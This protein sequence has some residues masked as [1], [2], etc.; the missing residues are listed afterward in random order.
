M[1]AELGGGRWTWLCPR[2]GP[3]SARSRPGSGRPTWEGG[4]V[5][6]EGAGLALGPVPL[7]QLALQGV[8]L[9][10]AA[11]DEV[12]GSPFRLHLDDKNLG[13]RP[14]GRTS[15]ARGRGGGGSGLPGLEQGFS[16]AGRPVQ[17]SMWAA[18][19]ASTPW[20]PV[21][22]P[23][24]VVTIKMPE[25]TDCHMPPE[26]RT[27]LPRTAGWKVRDGRVKVQRSE[28]RG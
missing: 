10:V 14:G 1:S 16:V 17:G 12:L 23:P 4:Q 11:V 19:P 26:G 9:A 18:S 21:A 5:A 27:A 15:E 25:G 24:H 8:E 20:V 13:Q 3:S 28:G 2:P 6:G 22:P 7:L